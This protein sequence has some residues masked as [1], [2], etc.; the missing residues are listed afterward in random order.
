MSPFFDTDE[1]ADSQPLSL[2]SDFGFTA[3]DAYHLIS[4]KYAA[5]GL[6]FDTERYSSKTEASDIVCSAR[7]GNEIVGT[8]TVRFDSP[9]GLNADLLFGEEL[10]VWRNAGVKLAEFGRLAVDR[11]AHEPRQL[12]ARLFQLGYL[13]AHRRKGCERLII[14]V[15]P[16]HVAFYRRFL[17]L[18]PHTTAR[19]NP[20][21]DAP[22]VLM[23]LDFAHIRAQIAKWGGQP[24]L[25]DAAR[26]LYPLA[27]GPAEEAT[28][29]AKLM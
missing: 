6:G 22:A 26:S 3:D 14:E 28:M 21:V 4:R 10:N 8:M 16:R 11:K 15:N 23:S 29:L 27:W 9:Q 25:L 13:H 17:G 19:H 7:E 1:R 5:R 12:L 18:V 24:H 20:R 2:N